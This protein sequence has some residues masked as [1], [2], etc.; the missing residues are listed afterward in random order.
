MLQLKIS[1]I[2]NEYYFLLNFLLSDYKLIKYTLDLKL[3]TFI[4]VVKDFKTFCSS[5]KIFARNVYFL[6]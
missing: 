2:L 1:F 6:S 4:F 5:V 3:E